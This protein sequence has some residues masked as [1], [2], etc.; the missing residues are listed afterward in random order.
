MVDR[1]F[2]STEQEICPICQEVMV[3]GKQLM[4]CPHIYH[5]YC[6]VKFI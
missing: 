3:S 4:G 1:A 6:I 2:D 5:T